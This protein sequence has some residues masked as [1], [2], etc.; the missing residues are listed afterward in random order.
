LIKNGSKV[1]TLVKVKTIAEHRTPGGLTEELEK[2]K[3][4]S[5]LMRVGSDVAGVLDQGLVKRG[6]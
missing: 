2:L 3:F 5:S 4:F 1:C 6:P